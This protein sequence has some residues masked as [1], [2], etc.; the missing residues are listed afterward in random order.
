VDIVTR[1]GKGSPLTHQEFDDNFSA[2]DS[3]RTAIDSDTSNNYYTQTEVDS[4]LD[5]NLSLYPEGLPE[6]ANGND[7]L[8]V[9]DDLSLDWHSPASDMAIWEWS[10]DFTYMPATSRQFGPRSMPWTSSTTQAHMYAADPTKNYITYDS[11]GDGIVIGR[12]GL[13]LLYQSGFGGAVSTSNGAQKAHCWYNLYNADKTLKE[14]MIVLGRSGISN[15]G[16]SQTRALPFSA[17]EIVVLLEGERLKIFAEARTNT[18]SNNARIA[19]IR[20]G[21][22]LVDAIDNL[23]DIIT[24]VGP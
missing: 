18:S 7:I 13:Y 3:S 21:F 8:Y 6:S 11:D 22:T 16:S 5:S 23:N 9:K 14:E 17:I 20:W 1:A 2:I 19:R 4:M 24:E 10:Q 15:D 12:T